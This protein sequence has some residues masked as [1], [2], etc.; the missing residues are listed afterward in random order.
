MYSHRVLSLGAVVTAMIATSGD[1]AFV[2]LAMIP[3]YNPRSINDPG[4]VVY[5]HDICESIFS[6][7]PK[8]TT[9]P[10]KIPLFT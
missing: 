2:M 6:S 10:A 9:N 3:G 7:L 5:N 4:N 1:E 8:P